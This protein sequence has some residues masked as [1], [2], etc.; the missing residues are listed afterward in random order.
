MDHF[1]LDCS[2][3]LTLASFAIEAMYYICGVP[4]DSISDPNLYHIINKSIRG[5]FCSV[6]QRHVIASNKDTNTN[7]DSRKMESN[8]LLYIDYNSLYPTI[9]S[10]FKLPTGD[11]V[12]LNAEE[13]DKFMKQDLTQIDVESDTDYYLYC[14]IK[15]IG[16]DIIDKSDAFPLLLSPMNIQPEKISEFSRK[17]MPLNSTKLVA[18]HCGVK[19]YLIILP[20]GFFKS[21]I[22]F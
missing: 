21:K 7:F 10:Q 11:F 18:H 17:L 4:L 12:E 14:D 3:F 16:P 9:M 15:L 19:N 22:F 6:G 8:Y 13:V 5:G 2:Y 1:K 20:G